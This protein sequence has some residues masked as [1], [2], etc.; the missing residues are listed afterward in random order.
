MDLNA[1]KNMDMEILRNGSSLRIFVLETLGCKTR[2][3]MT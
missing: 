2:T 3:V 1:L